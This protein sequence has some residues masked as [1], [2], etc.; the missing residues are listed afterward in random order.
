VDLESK[1][2]LRFLPLSGQQIADLR[3][4]FPE[5][6]LSSVAP[7]LY[8]SLLTRYD[9]VGLY[10]FAVGQK[11]LPDNLVYAILDA[12][13]SHSDELIA[14][15]PAATETVP[16]NFQRNTF[17]PFHNGAARWY[18]NRAVRGIDQGD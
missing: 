3:L 18:G 5:L 6:T 2:K 17:L 8:S 13:F 10:N 14:T 15:H 9:T 1:G 7:G 4:A 16:V 12:V 11:D